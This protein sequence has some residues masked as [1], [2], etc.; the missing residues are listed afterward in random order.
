MANTQKKSGGQRAASSG[1]QSGSKSSAS[2]S[3]SNKSKSGSSSRGKSA[4]QKRPIRRELWA[5]VCLLLAVL[6]AF[7]YFGIEAIFIDFFCGLVKG[8]FGYG[9]WLAPPALLLSAFILA[10]HRGRPVRMRVFFALMLPLM[11]SSVLH[12]LLCQPLPWDQ[13]LAKSLWTSGTDLSSGGVLGGILAQG[14]VQLVSQLGSTII[15]T[16][17][18]LLMGLGAFNR[19]IVDVADWIF[20]RPH[21]EYEVEE[22]PER[23]RRQPKQVAAHTAPPA[24]SQSSQRRTPD[25][26]IPVDEGPLVGQQPKPEVPVVEKK[27]GSFFNRKSRVPAPDQLLTGVQP[28]QPEVQAEPAIAALAAQAP[29][30]DVQRVG[31]KY[32]DAAATLGKIIVSGNP[33]G[34]PLQT[35]LDNAVAGI[36]APADQ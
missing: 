26:D 21:Y 23:P 25:I 28:A 15:Y 27:K 35:L 4:P 19:T 22:I 7:G 16:L 9:Y 8:L 1:K 11:F 13:A 14:G 31:S 32:W 36:T 33:D 34:T 5:V 12:G 3:T 17:A 29:Y 30:A 10:F 24:L 18:F 6:G 2:K 20:N